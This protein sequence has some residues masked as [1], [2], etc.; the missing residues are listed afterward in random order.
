MTDTLMLELYQAFA[1]AA[2]AFVAAGVPTVEVI[3]RYRGQPLNPEQFEYFPLPAIFIST[4]MT[5]QKIGNLYNGL[6]NWEL[7]IVNE[8][9]WE[10]SSIA[11]NKEEGLQY[12]RYVN[13]VRKVMDNFES[14]RISKPLRS[15]D[16]EID[17]GVIIY[18]V[19]GYTST[20][21]EDEPQDQYVDTTIEEV[22][23]EPT[24]IVKVLR[25]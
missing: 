21:Y 10:M 7:H 9:T 15:T 3:D 19:L 13:E 11:T 17:T 18:Q 1:D 22:N 14:E 20:Y 5:W 23:I 12:Y 25:K 6:L 16:R 4:S 24:R 2:P 8:P